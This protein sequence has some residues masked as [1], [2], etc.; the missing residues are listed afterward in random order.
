MRRLC[1]SA[2][3]RRKRLQGPLHT[4][5]APWHLTATK[6]PPLGPSG[7]ALFTGRFGQPM[8]LRTTCISTINARRTAYCPPRENPLVSPM[9]SSV[10]WPISKLHVNRPLHASDATTLITPTVDRV[11][12]L[13]LQGR[14]PDR[15]RVPSPR[16]PRPLNRSSLASTVMRFLSAEMVSCRSSAAASTDDGIGW[17]CATGWC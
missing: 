17:E 9:G 12:K 10:H 14:V 8:T 4:C 3:R 6:M 7:S 15:D 11:Q 1:V 16:F 13:F 2:R 5:S